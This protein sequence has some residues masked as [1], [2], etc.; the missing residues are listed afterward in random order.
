[1]HSYTSARPAVELGSIRGYV[2]DAGWARIPKAKIVLQKKK[3]GAFL[4]VGSAESDQ[5]GAFDFGKR[6][7]G[8]Y[9][10]VVDAHGFCGVVI[11]IKLSG[12]GW[13]GLK[14]ALPVGVTDTP[15]GYCDKE[16][17]IERWHQ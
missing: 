8:T 9:R 11:P 13:P 16:L 12:E 1:V 6:S 10:L 7:P 3:R 17:K 2:A 15:S 14:M 5:S 4:D